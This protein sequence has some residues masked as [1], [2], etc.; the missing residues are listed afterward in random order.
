MNVYAPYGLVI[1]IATLLV[2]LA[3]KLRRPFCELLCPVGTLS[4]LLLK[5]EGL[6]S[7][8]ETLQDAEEE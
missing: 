7:V 8:R 2:L 6:P 1:G 4:S 3:F 5:I